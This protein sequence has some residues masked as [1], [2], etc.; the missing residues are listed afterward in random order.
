MTKFVIHVRKK[1]ELFDEVFNK[2]EVSGFKRIQV[3]IFKAVYMKK[4]HGLFFLLRN[5]MSK[6]IIQEGKD[7]F[8]SQEEGD[9]EYVVLQKLKFEK[10]M[11]SEERNLKE[12]PAY[13]S[14]TNDRIIIKVLRF[15]KRGL[16]NKADA[17]KTA[18]GYGRVLDFFNS[19]GLEVTWKIE[20]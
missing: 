8:I 20:E 14:F 17:I 5:R 15:M 2:M 1:T 9:L 7:Y 3:K 6:W 10:F 4:L 18:L 16:A 11:I 19:C 12:N 13:N